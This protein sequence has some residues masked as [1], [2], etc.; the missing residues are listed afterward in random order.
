[1]QGQGPGDGPTPLVLMV[2]SSGGHLAQLLS[3]DPWSSRY[4][5]RWVTFGTVDA[6]SALEGRD[7]VECY[8][9]TTRNVRNLL[10]NT[11]LA[12]HVLR[13][14]RP[15]VVISSGAAVAVPFFVLSRVLGVPTV[16]VEVFDRLDSRTLT[17]R[18]VRPFTSRFLVQWEEQLELYKGSIL[19]G[20]LL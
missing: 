10:R 2:C 19:V 9:P 18:L 20:E 11:R 4:R 12:W 1:M 17:G 16:Y 3:L 6:R 5:T 14:D 7:V 13:A 8:H 15:A